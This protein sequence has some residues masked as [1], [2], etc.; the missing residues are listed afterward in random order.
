MVKEFTTQSDEEVTWIGIFHYH[1]FVLPAIKDLKGCFATKD[2]NGVKQTGL[3]NQFERH[4]YSVHSH[5][6][7]KKFKVFAMGSV[8]NEE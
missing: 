7:K 4:G 3:W 6:G 5:D 8:V 1:K 2:N